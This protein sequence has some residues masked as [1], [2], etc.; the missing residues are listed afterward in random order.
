MLILAPAGCGKTEALSLKVSGLLERGLVQRPRVVL[1]VTFT[2]RAR[3]NIRRRLKAQLSERALR[4]SVSIANFHGLASRIYQAHARSVGLDPDAA[5]PSSDWIAEQC[6]A[7]EFDRSRKAAVLQLLQAVKQED[8]NDEQVASRLAVAGDQD[9]IDIEELRRRENRLTYDDLPRLANVILRC[10]GVAQLYRSH[11]AAVIVDEFQDLTPQQLRM[12]DF[13]G[14]DVTTFAGDLAQGIYS[15]AG[16][17]PVDVYARIK[18]RVNSIVAF[19]ESHRSS[20]AVLGMVNSLTGLTGGTVLTS[21]LPARWPNGGLAAAFS[22]ADI[23]AESDWV[24]RFCRFILKLAPGHRIGVMSRTNP[25]RQYV[26]SSL[27]AQ[28]IPIWKWDDP[29][30][31]AETARTLRSTLR[32]QKPVPVGSIATVAQTLLDST[33]GLIAQDPLLLTALSQ[34]CT[35][36]AE[37][38]VDGVTIDGVLKRVKVGDEATLLSAPGVHLLSGHV[39]KGQQFDWVVI[40]GA[41]EGCLPD[42]RCTTEDEVAEEARILSVMLSRARHGVVVVSTAAVP[43]ASGYV[44]GR[45]VSRFV[46]AFDS[47]EDLNDQAGAVAW[48]RAADW[49]QIVEV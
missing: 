47:L 20:P 33:K 39:G 38:L 46:A 34:A 27:T 12:V 10:E 18:P 44:R 37:L 30:L 1:V 16:A 6:I 13:L 28:G 26:E 19:T 22:V 23:A 43:T 21:A 29:L 3:D 14:A 32:S 8:L 36:A 31:D 2:N 5:M 49:A 45:R 15:F 11:F 24:M 4:E 25:R 41:E 9:A 35:W 42:F 17:A 7:R 48:L 40:V